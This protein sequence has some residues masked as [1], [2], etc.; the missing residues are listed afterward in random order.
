M[1]NKWVDSSRKTERPKRNVVQVQGVGSFVDT[2]KW[3]LG[4]GWAVKGGLCF[5][6][7]ARGRRERERRYRRDK[8]MI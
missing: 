4:I 3:A 6:E 2:T 1:N 7:N 5:R 8:R